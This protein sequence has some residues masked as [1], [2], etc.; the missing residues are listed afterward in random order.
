MRDIHNEIAAA[1][2][3]YNLDPNLIK[4]VMKSE[5]NFNPNAVS[6]AGAMGLMQLMPRTAESLGVN[7][8]FDIGQNIDGGASYLRRMLDMFGGDESLALAA[9][10]A[11]PN[12]VRRHDGIPPFNETQ[13]YVPKVMGYREQ[14]ILEQYRE[15]AN[16]I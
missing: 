8:P 10:N 14:Y 7:D 5:S 15:A 9:Y 13:R 12:A 11:G 2:Q 16:R 6:R 4:A 1:A 3:K